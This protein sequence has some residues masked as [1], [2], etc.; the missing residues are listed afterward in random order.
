MTKKYFYPPVHRQKAYFQTSGASLEN[1]DFVSARTITLPL[2]PQLRD[3]EVGRICAAIE[4]V[5]F[6][7]PAVR[8]EIGSS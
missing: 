8:T 3:E 2:F 6:H 1:T 7:A 4:N 5:H